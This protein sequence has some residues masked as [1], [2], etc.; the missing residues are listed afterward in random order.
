MVKHGDP[1]CIGSKMGASTEESSTISQTQNPFMSG[2]GRADMWSYELNA[3]FTKQTYIKNPGPGQYFSNKR[4]DDIKQR[5]LQEETVTVPFGGSDDRLCN[6]PVKAPFPGPGSYIDVNNPNNSSV[7]KSLAKIQ[8]DRQLAASQG[9][10][11][12]AFGS[13]TDRNTYWVE[14]KEGPAPGYYDMNTDLA[15]ATTDLAL[16]GK[17]PKSRVRTSADIESKMPNS[18]FTSN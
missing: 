8:E 17:A 2:T 9:V 6:K 5:L 12:G 16:V 3:P 7:C 10:K 18:V 11:L 14:A 13:T 15:D 4:K 1:S